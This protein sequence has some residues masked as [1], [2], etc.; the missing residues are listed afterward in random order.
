[1]FVQTAANAGAPFLGVVPLSQTIQ[2]VDIP[3]VATGSNMAVGDLV[4]LGNL[5]TA[6]APG[7]T[8]TVIGYTAT[9]VTATA[10]AAADCNIRSRKFLGVVTVGASQNATCVV[11][12]KGVVAANLASNGAVMSALVAGTKNLAN[13][14]AI[15]SATDLVVVGH[16]L[17]TGTGV[18]YIIFDGIQ[19]LG[20]AAI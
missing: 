20:S 8:E 14:A 2:N 19:G 16:S 10:A 11:R 15:G 7:Q 4:A 3:A 5:A 17:E 13:P 18:K 12:V 6:A 1:M 9:N